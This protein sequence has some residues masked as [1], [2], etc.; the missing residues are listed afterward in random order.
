VNKKSGFASEGEPAIS[1]LQNKGPSITS[2][3][4]Q[5]DESSSLQG[6]NPDRRARLT[7]PPYEGSAVPEGTLRGDGS[8][9]AVELISTPH[10]ICAG[11]SVLLTAGLQWDQM[12]YNRAISQYASSPAGP[13]A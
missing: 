13:P 11:P 3:I 4:R 7:Q 10:N 2:A 9:R 1:K 6:W 8:N 12:G 5:Y